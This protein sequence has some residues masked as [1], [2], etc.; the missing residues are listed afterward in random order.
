MTI[1]VQGKLREVVPEAVCQRTPLEMPTDPTQAGFAVANK[2]GFRGVSFLMPFQLN[3]P[4]PYF[5]FLNSFR[6]EINISLMK[7]LLRL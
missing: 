2:R 1:G 7:F 4:T 5:T 6:F 3:I